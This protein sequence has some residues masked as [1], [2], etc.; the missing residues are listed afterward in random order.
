[1]NLR[2]TITPLYGRVIV[3][4]GLFV[5]FSGSIGPKIISGGLLKNGGFEIYGSIGKAIIFALIAFILL[6]LSRTKH[7]KLEAWRPWLLWWFAAA[8]FA[9]SISWLSVNNLIN[10]QRDLLMFSWAHGGLWLGSFFIGLGCFG[11]KNLRLIWQN[12]RRDIIVAAGFGAIFYL[13]L[14]VVYALWLPLASIVMNQV[15]WL[16]EATGHVAA[17]LPPNKLILD[18]FGI[19]IAESCSGIES[20][21]LFTSL[22]AIVGLL[23]WRRLSKKL[24]F[25]IFPLALIVL[26]FFN[27]FRVYGL[28]VAG[29]HIN[30]EIAFS[31]FHTYAGM[32]F[33]IVYSATFWSIA[34]K[35][36]VKNPR[37][38]VVDESLA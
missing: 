31:L 38:E 6:T 2:Q 5:I 36:I 27:I 17:A 34:Y 18:K 4:L 22:Y 8:I 26:F 23:E 21:A 3:F 37:R 25:A 24:Y 35:K 29:Y 11:H 20:I 14:Y 16:L 1:M 30:P 33:F 12:Y 9:W 19:T 13:F 15:S 7:L 28:I 32:L 10:G